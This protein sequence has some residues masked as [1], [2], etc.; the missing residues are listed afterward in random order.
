LVGDI[1]II[2]EQTGEPI[3]LDGVF[4]S[5]FL[6]MSFTLEFDMADSPYSHI[7]IDTVRGVLG[8]DLKDIF[9]PPANCGDPNHPYPAGDIN[10]D[11]SVNQADAAI[12]A[13]FWLASG[14]DPNYAC[15]QADLNG[16]KNINLLDLARLQPNWQNSTWPPQ[17]GDPGYPWVTGDLNRDCRVEQ[18]DVLQMLDEWLSDDCDLLNWNCAGGDLNKNGTVNL[19]DFAILTGQWLT[20]THPDGC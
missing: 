19:E 1:G 20:C 2:D 5:N 4:G 10:Q 8:F 9:T 11:C 6:D 13:E 12:L 3:I 15:H 14:C 17:C 18:T 7:V 16:D